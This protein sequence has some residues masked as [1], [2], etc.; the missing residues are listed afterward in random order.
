[1][2][3][4]NFLL[5]A[6]ISIAMCIPPA[7]ASEINLTAAEISALPPYCAGRFAARSGNQQEFLRWKSKYGPDFDHTHHMCSG[8]GSINRS[9]R[10]KT[11]NE[12][13]E[14]LENAIKEL[15]YMVRNAKPDF[16]LMPEVYLNRGQAN[17][18]LGRHAVAVNDAKKALELDANM[19]MAYALAIDSYLKLGSKKEALDFAG[20]GLRHLPENTLLKKRYTELGGKQPFPEPNE[21]P[22]ETATAKDGSTPNVS[23]EA[24]ANPTANQAKSALFDFSRNVGAGRKIPEILGAGVYLFVEVREDPSAPEQRVLFRVMSQ[25]PQPFSQGASIGIDLGRYV[26]LFSGIKEGN[27]FLDKYYVLKRG[28]PHAYWPNFDPEYKADFYASDAKHYDPRALSPGMSVTFVGTLRPGKTIEDVVTAMKEGILPDIGGNGLR[29]G[30]IMHHLKGKRPDERV[31]IMDDGGF[32]TGGLRQ[33][34]GFP[35]L[36][37][38]KPETVKSSEEPQG[39]LAAS[40][41]AVN[42]SGTQASPANQEVTGGSAA[43]GSP[44]NPWC[45]FCPEPA[46]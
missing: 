20:E 24:A 29:F 39:E 25:V 10:A 12:K 18:L 38:P 46:K 32:L 3:L 26:D 15:D 4:V 44:T 35:S 6:V 5:L 37:P 36:E 21:K 41:N 34:T 1:M 16:K 17:A 23:S 13:A 27:G 40:T 33:I 11:Q 7:N 19:P 30:I 31:T 43:I 22:K 14:L 28:S 42:K 9:Y 8:I 2:R 45:R